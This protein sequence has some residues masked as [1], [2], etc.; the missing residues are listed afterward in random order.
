MNNMTYYIP[1]SGQVH[2][3]M[4]NLSIYDEFINYQ[5]YLMD[6]LQILLLISSEFKRIT[7]FY[8]PAIFPMILRELEVI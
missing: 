5:L 2:E 3:S 1:Y 4:T 8:F 7:N 6:L